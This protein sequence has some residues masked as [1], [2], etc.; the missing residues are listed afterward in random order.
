MIPNNA[1]ASR[2]KRFALASVAAL[3]V[4]AGVAFVAL[5]QRAEPIAR[6]RIIENLETKL[7]CTVELDGVHVA[8]THGLEVNGNGLRIQ[9]IGNQ[10]RATPGGAPMLSV[11]SFQFHSTLGDL[12]FHHTSAI[13]A[14]AQGLV[15][16]I[17]PGND[18]APLQQGDPAK[19]G[20]PRDSMFL[21]RL[22]ATDSSLVVENSDP[23]KPPIRLPFTKFILLD[24]G[25][26]D[27][28]HSARPFTYEAILT[29][30]KPLG[31]I[32]SE[33]HIGP[34]VFATPRTSPVDGNYTYDHVD[35]GTVNGISGT[36]TSAG[37][38]TGTLGAMAVHGTTDTPDFALDTSARPFAVHT[39][40]QALVDGTNGDVT[41]QAVT[42]HFLHTTVLATGSV[43]RA[44]EQKG[45]RT[46]VD[47]EIRAGRAEDLLTLFSKTPSP[48]LT[49]ALVLRGRV[50]VPPGKQ[51]LVLKLEAVGKALLTGAVW[52]SPEIQ[53]QVDSFSLRATDQGK[54]RQAIQNPAASPLVASTLAGAFRIKGGN[55]EVAGLSYRVPGAL[56]LM[57]GR[58]PLVDREL[59][60][61][62]V[63]RTD[64]PAAHMEAG[65]KR[66][67]IAPISPLLHKHGAGM[68]LPVSFTGDK[69]QPHFALDLANRKVD[70]E[71]TAAR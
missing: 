19:R 46:E 38:I 47:A 62:G 53:G 11:R 69:S 39:E 9:S 24:P 54:A 5:R 50:V 65:W 15:L 20:Q 36:L 42:A 30:P 48:M 25:G 32:H 41:L 68:E 29:S 52:S 59:D 22:V 61:H 12:L 21:N 8:F 2:I 18:R 4:L 3:L 66:L 60:F 71:K 43:K 51:R 28:G 33:G 64:A 1:P 27:E 63:A 23:S 14:Y 16:T 45:H 40:F 17:P 34:W 6:Q 37:R 55:I 44:V 7:H 67:L 13:T 70:E 35:L 26:P 58:Y 31:E 56:M 10:Q 57:D 49:S